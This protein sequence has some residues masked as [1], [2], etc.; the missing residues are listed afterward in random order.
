MQAKDTIK[1]LSR[2]PYSENLNLIRELVNLTMLL[3]EPDPGISH[4][5][6]IRI[7]SKPC[8]S[9]SIEAEFDRELRLCLTSLLVMV[10]SFS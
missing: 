8:D 10:F 1:S 3:W 9:V 5:D 4:L 2:S 7:L 6:T